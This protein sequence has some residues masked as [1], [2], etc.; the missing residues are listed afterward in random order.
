MSAALSYAAQ[1]FMG[2]IFEVS[3]TTR[4]LTSAKPSPTARLNGPKIS[5]RVP[6]ESFL[7]L[8]VA[9]DFT[10]EPPNRHNATMQTDHS[11][12]VLSLPRAENGI[13][14]ATWS[15]CTH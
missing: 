3:S 8:G 5:T 7:I 11:T 2:L 12:R 15:E 9:A 13:S 1:D 10:R 4:R 14:R 6:A